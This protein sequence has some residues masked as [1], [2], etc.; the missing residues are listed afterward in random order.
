MEDARG[1]DLEAAVEWH[2]A[3][4]KAVAGANV[5][6]LLDSLAR[7]EKALKGQREGVR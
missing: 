4:I 1:P 6:V 7:V 2:R 5:A 3:L